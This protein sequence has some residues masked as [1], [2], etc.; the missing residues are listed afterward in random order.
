MKRIEELVDERKEKMREK[1]NESVEPGPEIIKL[2]SCSTHYHAQLSYAPNEDL[3]LPAHP[4]IFI[5]VFIVRM[6]ELH[7]WLS[8]T[9]SDRSKSL[10][11]TRLTVHFLTLQLKCDQPTIL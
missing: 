2:F 9:Y 7:P 8:K 11:D 5:R 10:L 3:N 1:A 6:K 4:H